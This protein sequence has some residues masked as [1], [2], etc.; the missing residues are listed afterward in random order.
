MKLTFPLKGQIHTASALVSRKGA[1]NLIRV[2]KLSARNR[3]SELTKT[4]LNVNL[5]ILNRPISAQFIKEIKQDNGFYHLKFLEISESNRIALNNFITQYGF[6]LLA[7]R[8]WPRIY[9]GSLAGNV[10]VPDYFQAAY[11]GQSLFFKVI[12]YSLNSFLFSLT[13]KTYQEIQIHKE[14]SGDLLLDSGEVLTGFNG[15]VVRTTESY[16]LTEE[17]PCQEVAIEV[18]QIDEDSRRRFYSLIKQ[19]CLFIKK[20]AS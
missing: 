5:E 3:L 8:K 17:S 12:N 6:P 14:I 18:H 10:P 20:R 13:E 15:K 2:N 19:Q 9:S 4:P 7:E 1:L 11:Q 16:N